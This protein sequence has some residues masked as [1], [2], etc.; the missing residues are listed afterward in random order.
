MG[1]RNPAT[2]HPHGSETNNPIQKSSE[3]DNLFFFFHANTES[4]SGLVFALLYFE[5]GETGSYSKLKLRQA[6]NLGSSHVVGRTSSAIKSI[7]HS[8]R[9]KGQSRDLT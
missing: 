8:L 5:T 2:N 6:L 4:A 9:S 1:R 3:K 7:K